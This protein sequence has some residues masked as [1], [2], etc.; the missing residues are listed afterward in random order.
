MMQEVHSLAT[1]E[2]Q[3][4]GADPGG[5]AAAVRRRLDVENG[6]TDIKVCTTGV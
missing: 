3:A 5:P 4:Y 1:A 6:S 2:K